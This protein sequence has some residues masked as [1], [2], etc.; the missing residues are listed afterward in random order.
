MFPNSNKIMNFTMVAYYELKI[1]FHLPCENNI[2]LINI[3]KETVVTV[4]DSQ[5]FKLYHDSPSTFGINQ[6]FNIYNNNLKMNF[7][8]VVFDG[9]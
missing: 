5:H 9:I 3:F 6:Q 8:L 7:T 2:T 4:C 1:I